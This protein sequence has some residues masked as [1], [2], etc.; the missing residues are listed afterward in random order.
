M[1]PIIVGA[2]PNGL[3]CAFYLAKAGL[4]PLVLEAREVVGGGAITSELHPGFRCPTLTHVAGP[5]GP[6]IAA[7]LNL[8]H[9]GIEFIRADPRLFA[10][11]PD[12]RAV[13]LY[14]DPQRSADRLKELSSD[15]AARFVEFHE[16]LGAMGK[17]IAGLL[18]MAPPDIDEPAAGDL[19]DL[20][21]LGR[22]YKALGRANEFRLLRWLPMAVA[23]LVAEWFHTDL[24]RAAIAARGIFGTCMGPRS[25]GS[26]AVML[27]RT[28]TDP[29]PAGTSVAVR[30]G[31]GALTTAIAAAAVR[32]GAEIRTGAAVGRIDV[33]NGGVTGITLGTGEQVPAT[34]VVSAVDPKRTFLRLVDPLHLDPEFL[35]KIRNYRSEGTVA[36]VNLA[37]A[38]MPRFEAAPSSGDRSL[39][40]GRIHIGPGMDYLERAFDAAKYGAISERPY[41]EATLPSIADP[42][43]VPSG[44]HVMSVYV[45]FAPYSLRG[46]TWDE[47]REPLADLVVNTLAEYAPNLRGLIVQREVITPLD[48]ETRYGLTGGHIFHGELALDQL[49]T[50]RPLLGWAR[51][52]TPLPNLYLCGSG[53]HPGL[54]LTGASG[55]NAAREI[56][57]D[58]KGRRR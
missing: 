17:L 34:A 40:A 39:L 8:K 57:K 23:D 30:G 32:A 58:L 38:G 24:L 37:L 9:A 43:L 16:T 1:R 25:A 4:K 14:E 52:R 11:G 45:Q 29:H 46:T 3:T 18:R 36:K 56:V 33:A 27:L 51:Y 26:G 44:A 42:S 31:P 15:D 35:L 47:R 6:D 48:L 12:G 53:T 50:M 20:A 5:L 7:D 21:K 22:Q 54:G 28:A 41:L 13:V 2:G 55:A 19:W 49:F 10:P